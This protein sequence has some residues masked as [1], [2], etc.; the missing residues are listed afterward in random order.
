MLI[1]GG[2]RCNV[3]HACFEPRELV[4]KYPRGSN[5]LL[6]PFHKWQPG[7][8]MAWFE[9]KGVSLKTEGDGRVFPTSDSSGT[10]V[11]CLI[12]SA[13]AFDIDIRPR[14]GVLSIARA[15]PGRFLLSL[16][17]AEPV[18][19]DKVLIAS[20][21]GAKSGGLKMAQDL[22]HTITELAPS[23]FTFHIDDPR[24]RGLQGLSLP[25]VDVSCPEA[26]L[27]ESGPLLITHWGL[28]GPAIL[29][30]SALGARH[31]AQR[32]YTFDIFIHWLG[33]VPLEKVQGTL[34]RQKELTGKKTVM[35]APHF[36][37]PKR[38]WERLVEASGI[39][40]DTQW[41][42][43]GKQQLKQLTGELTQGVFHVVDKSMN[44]EEFVTC[45]GVKLDEVNFKTMESRKVAGLYFAGEVLDIDGVTGGFNFQAAWTTGKIA[46]SSMAEKLNPKI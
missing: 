27:R 32:H 9:E 15:D 41:A 21:G 33:H 42:Q 2:G 8:T 12:G 7:D 1:S 22:G 14:T 3:T 40:L 46:G 44:K 10:I 13:K 30:L 4:K 35:A 45:G 26:R 43:L 11:D 36:G 24:I 20:G 19:V 17:N 23:L 29:K 37:L 34:Q 5:E 18:T 6:G 25:D 28:S 39:S 38:I 16:E 31:F